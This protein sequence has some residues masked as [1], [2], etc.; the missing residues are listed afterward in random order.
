MEVG[1]PATGDQPFEKRAV[2]V[3]FPPEAQNDIP[4][5]MQISPKHGIIYMITKD[6]N[7]HLYNLE[8][9][10]CIY[11][12]RI[13]DV[14]IFVMAPYEPTSGII[15]VNENGQVRPWLCYHPNSFFLCMMLKVEWVGGL[16]YLFWS[17]HQFNILNFQSLGPLFGTSIKF[18]PWH[19]YVSHNGKRVIFH[20]STIGCVAQSQSLS[21]SQPSLFKFAL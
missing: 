9:G 2:D 1:S 16:R 12:S 14:P 3:Y 18:C 4:V 5:A 7:I 10:T 6:G 8:T 17:A 13:S 11:M 20:F 15:C 21:L 19:Y